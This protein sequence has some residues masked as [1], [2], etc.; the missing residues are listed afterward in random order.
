MR[1]QSASARPASAT[2]STSIAAAIVTATAAR[3]NRCLPQRAG[4][5]CP[6]RH[7]HGTLLEA[8]Q[9]GW[10]DALQAREC[11][12]RHLRH[13]CRAQRSIRRDA[14]LQK[15][16]RRYVHQPGPLRPRGRHHLRRL[17]AALAATVTATARATACLTTTTLS[18]PATDS[19][20]TTIAAATVTT[21]I[22]VAAMPSDTAVVAATDCTAFTATARLSIALLP[23][24]SA[25]TLTASILTSHPFATS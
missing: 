18:F 1:A 19:D 12:I 4:A 9:E 3:T 10:R 8:R 24:P 7:G 13:V 11:R 16:P 23:T 6:E 14:W 22:A 20:I 5:V 17:A 15:V 2:D 21:S 25:T